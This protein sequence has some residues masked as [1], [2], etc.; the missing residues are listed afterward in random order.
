M[1]KMSTDEPSG[2]AAFINT[3]AAAHG[4]KECWPGSRDRNPAVNAPAMLQATEKLV[5]SP[6]GG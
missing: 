4:R 5:W 6:T 3:A 2:A 1:S